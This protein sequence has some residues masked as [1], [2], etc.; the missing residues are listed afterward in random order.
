MLAIEGCDCTNN[1]TPSKTAVVTAM[2][3]TMRN[4]M[5]DPTNL[6]TSR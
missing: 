3:F 2:P 4:V 1:A 6:V 5:T